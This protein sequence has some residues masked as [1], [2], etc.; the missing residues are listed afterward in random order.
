MWSRFRHSRE[1]VLAE[2]RLS[3][4]AHSIT[5]TSS[6]RLPTKAIDLT[7]SVDYLLRR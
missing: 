6:A 5:T 2:S 3:F 1:F 4:P 7:Q